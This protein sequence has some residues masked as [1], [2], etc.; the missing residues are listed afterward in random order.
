MSH[1][2]SNRSNGSF[3]E[4][5]RSDGEMICIDV[6]MRRVDVAEGEPFIAITKEDV[7]RLQ[8]GP[9]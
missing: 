6:S 4:T 8:V 1:G 3:A 5:A 7:T 2:L 9:P